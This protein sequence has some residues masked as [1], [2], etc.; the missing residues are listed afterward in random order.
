M[1]KVPSV[2]EARSRIKKAP[3]RA[4]TKAIGR[5][6]RLPNGIGDAT[7][8]AESVELDKNQSGEAPEDPSSKRSDIS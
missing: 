4:Q 6:R 8:P 7:E 3:M 5:E 2:L 1:L